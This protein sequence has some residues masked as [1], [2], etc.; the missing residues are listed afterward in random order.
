M[1]YQMR[2]PCRYCN[3][4]EGN[5]SPRGGQNCVFCLGCGRLAYNAPRTETGETV[6]TVTTIHNGIRPKQRARILLRANGVCELCGA[7]QLLHVGHL[8][9]VDDGLKAGST[10]A[11]LNSDENLAALCEE[12]NLGIG[13]A[14][15]TLRLLMRLALERGAG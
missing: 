13:S 9:S 11:V 14:S 5:I 3:S 1:A 15:V 4:E 2:E 6:R 7:R 10:E 12:C 8:L